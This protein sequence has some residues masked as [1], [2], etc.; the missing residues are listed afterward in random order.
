MSSSD[1]EQFEQSLNQIG[2]TY[3]KSSFGNLIIS[4]FASGI[5]CFMCLY[6]L[7][8]L[9]E[10]TQESR[11][12]RSAY[13]AV[14]CLIFVTYALAA[15][16]DALNMFDILL[17]ASN[18]IDI[19]DYML[20][21]ATW[22]NYLILSC[23]AVL[24][25]LG[26]GLLLYRC[27]IVLDTRRWIIAFPTLTYVG[28][29]ATSIAHVVLV[30][31]DSESG[32]A[33]EGA[34]VG[35]S[36]ATNVTITSLIA[37]HLI[38]SQRAL[39]RALPEKDVAIYGSIAAILVE[40]AVPLMIAGLGY[41]VTTF[42]FFPN[43]WT[44]ADLNSVLASNVT[45]ATLYYAFV[46]ISPLMIIFRVTNG[47]SWTT[48]TDA[49]GD[50]SRRAVHSGPLVFARGTVGDEEASYHPRRESSELKVA[51]SSGMNSNST[52]GGRF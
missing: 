42:A 30:S 10:S 13:V 1:L 19:S 29:I 9:L 5:Q 26:D 23:Y 43:V 21:P 49:S 48:G 20:E 22:S 16:L 38:K 7:S 47:R 11:K 39:A 25:I 46:A 34:C 41:F 17:P 2:L 28:M 52:F 40:S 50:V 15:S 51:S 31:A 4:I 14:G 45:F 12:G 8:R 37:F 35:L 44:P 36:V 27:Y 6:C 33:L 32:T 18:G 3:I 24:L